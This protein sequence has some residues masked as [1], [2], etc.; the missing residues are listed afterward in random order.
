MENF[1]FSNPT[2]IIF[3]IDA[4][5]KIADE[6]AVYGVKK[7][8]IVYGLGSIRQNGIYDRVVRRIIKK[9]INFIDFAGAKPNPI[10][11]HVAVG[12]ELAKKSGVDGVLAIGGGSSIDTA[13]AIAAGVLYDGDVWDFFEGRAEVGA[14]LP[15]FTVLTIAAAGSEMNG[16]SVITKEDEKKKYSFS[17]THSY[18]KAS[19]LNP[20]LTFSVSI[21][22]SACGI[23]DAMAHLLEG[24]FTK[25]NELQLHD[26]L[27]E[28]V[29]KTIMKDAETILTEP[30]NYQ[31]RSSFMWSATLALNG[32]LAQGLKEHS[33]PNHLIEHSLSALHG[34]THGEGLAIVMPAWM[35]WMSEKNPVRFDRFAKKIFKKKNAHEGIDAFE[36]WLKKIG[37]STRLGEVGVKKTDVE[38]M[39]V[40]ANALAKVWRKM[41]KIYTKPA[42]KEILLRAF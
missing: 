38:A 39:A 42:L 4:E 2:K 35:R 9:N 30:E 7:L 24:Y 17:S 22:Q 25:Q 13:K 21:K 37:L 32:F 34:V 10:L 19:A 1:V 41:D 31:A 8:M 15:I 33:F 23:A 40:N 20:K 3:G 6:I 36:A 18:P 27:V 16:N 26:R 29:I 5:L 28:G 11:S 14:S 12:I